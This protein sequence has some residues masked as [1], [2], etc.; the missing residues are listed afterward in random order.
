MKTEN[1]GKTGLPESP[2]FPPRY[3]NRFT[4]IEL[5]IRSSIKEKCLQYLPRQELLFSFSFKKI[6]FI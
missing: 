2:L 6:F 3:A 4:L 1:I 5:L